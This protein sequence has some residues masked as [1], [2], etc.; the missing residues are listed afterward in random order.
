M[1]SAAGET[2]G[3][4]RPG[5]R[6]AMH[7]IQILLP[8]ADN[9][10]HPFPDDVLQA[11]QTELSERFGGLTAYNR[12]PARGVWTEGGRGE[13]K[14]D[15]VSPVGCH[16]QIGCGPSNR[17]WRRAAAPLFGGSPAR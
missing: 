8:L 1:G 3:G 12:A 4:P 5:A 17:H 15:R 2:A 9:A 7:L 11:I 16:K 10:G 6:I 14:L 13:E